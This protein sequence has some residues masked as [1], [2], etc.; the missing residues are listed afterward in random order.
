MKGK[1]ISLTLIIQTKYINNLVITNYFIVFL[2]ILIIFIFVLDY[3]T[4][5]VNISIPISLLAITIVTYLVI[6]YA[7]KNR[8]HSNINLY[9]FTSNQSVIQSL[10]N[11]IGGKYMENFE[12]EELELS[13][14]ELDPIV[15]DVV[16]NTLKVGSNEA[17]D[18]MDNILA[19]KINADIE[20]KLYIT[21]PNTEEKV[22]IINEK[23][24][25]INGID[26]NI[27]GVKYGD[28]WEGWPS[29][30]TSVKNEDVQILRTLENSTDVKVIS[31]VND[32]NQET[33]HTIYTFNIP[34]G[35]DYF[36]C[37]VLVVGGGSFGGY[38]ATSQ[39]FDNLEGALPPVTNMGEGGAGGAVILENLN[40]TPGKYEFGI[41]RGGYWINDNLERSIAE[42]QAGS[43]Y[44]KNIDSG[45]I[46]VLAKGALFAKSSARSE[47]QFNQQVSGGKID[48][49]KAVN[50]LDALKNGLGTLGVK[51]NYGNG[52][53]GGLIKP[54]DG[55]FGYTYLE[56]LGDKVDTYYLSSYRYEGN[57]EGGT[58]GSDGYDASEYFGTSYNNGIFAAGGGAASYCKVGDTFHEVAGKWYTCSASAD[59]AGIGG[60]GGGGNGNPMDIG[61]DAVH[62]SGSGG[63]G[64][65]ILGGNGGAGVI[66]LKFDIESMR[67]KITNRIDSAK[68]KLKQAIYDIGVEESNKELRK[69]KLAIAEFLRE[70]NNDK[71]E[72]AENYSKIGVLIETGKQQQ[73]AIDDY[74]EL[75][76]ESETDQRLLKKKIQNYNAQIRDYNQK[77]AQLTTDGDIKRAKLK[78]LIT[79]FE[80]KK[81][82]F[83]IQEKSVQD[84]EKE[85]KRKEAS[86]AEHKADYLKSIANRLKAEAC[87]KAFRVAQMQKSKDILATRKIEMKLKREMMEAAEKKRITAIQET[88]KAEKQRDA[89][90]NDQYEAEK[91]FK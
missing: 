30:N 83:V 50:L 57:D 66:L 10:Y 35:I 64:G 85:E 91:G 59:R 81:A 36:P 63:G 17:L 42:S 3:S 52:G 33:T 15:K 14:E 24:N 51:N 76:K 71:A 68:L 25:G 8:F 47:T 20:Q 9:D 54:E 27:L 7:M 41:G 89:A 39:E 2:L 38:I 88:I 73:E 80:I 29:Q 46:Y 28:L 82:K 74:N 23:I 61:K 32:Q 5:I 49:N 22:D 4:S 87:K 90:L 55:Q 18:Q 86:L 79:D 45:E 31:F 77:I 65:K 60:N 69:K 72:I 40:L 12:D 78:E 19:T 56:T 1:P 26:R 34:E 75:L 48:G 53:R 62:G 67:K 6:N 43:S 21:I 16:E 37:Q 44:I 58:N 13:E 70:I 11:T 84:K